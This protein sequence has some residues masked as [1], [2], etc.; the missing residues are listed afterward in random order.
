M[1]ASLPPVTVIG[2]GLGGLSAAIH[3]RLAGHAVQ[4]LEKNAITGGR[5]GRLTL[6][7]VR[8]DTGPT[9]LDYPW[10]FE[11]LFQA[12]GRRLADYVELLPVEPML[13]CCWSDGRRLTLS[14]RR[15]ELRAELERLEPGAGRA[16][17][18]FFADAG[19]KFRIA[20]EKLIPRDAENP[21]R[22]FAALGWREWARTGLWRSMYGELGRFFRSRQIREALGCYAM[23]LG[24]SPFRLPGMFSLLPYGELAHGLWIPRGGMYALVEGMER[25]A[26]ELGVQ[27]RT[28]C[29]VERILVEQDRVR[30]VRLADGEQSPA[31][32]AVCNVDLPAAM[33]D[34]LGQ[35]PPRIAMSPAV[36]TYYWIVR[37]RPAGLGH[38]T[39]FLPQDYRGAFRRLQYGS[40]LPADPAFYV[41]APPPDGAKAGADWLQPLFVLVPAPPLS[42]LAGVDWPRAVACLR[43]Q[44]LKRMDQSGIALP[45][46]EL[47]E[48]RVWSPPEWKERFGLF[49]GSAFGA[50]HTLG[51]IGP[52]RP[53][54]YSR[55][56]RG[57]YFTGASTN[58]GTGLPMVVISGRLTAERIASHVR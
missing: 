16:L 33:T 58:P 12:A 54:N 11:E 45:A 32:L 42:R 40:G 4:I 36:V 52:F 57:L 53:R 19:E 10:V 6:R 48:E 23:Y 55:R 31:E 35:R 3:L 34:L 56:I 14:S 26:R 13:T 46:A 24:G 44:I 2:A 38:H 20:F 25:L 15:E 21:L 7:G 41:A 49:D 39:I 30:A 50:A 51:Q 47:V 8:F 1:S 27:I 28:G 29:R 5:A 18:R 22:Y 9:L 37:R 43:E 17:D